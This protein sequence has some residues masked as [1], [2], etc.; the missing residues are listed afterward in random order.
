MWIPI[1][2]TTKNTYCPLLTLTSAGRGPQ[3]SCHCSP[4][5]QSHVLP[6]SWSQQPSSWSWKQHAHGSTLGST[7][8]CMEVPCTWLHST[9][10][11]SQS[12][13]AC[14]VESSTTTAPT[15]KPASW[16]PVP[17]GILQ[18]MTFT[19]GGKE[20][21]KHQNSLCH[22]ATVAFTTTMDT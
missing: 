18:A 16:T 20:K 12:T 14:T 5:E 19:H 7:A 13:S 21:R 1:A 11:H 2:F 3:S 15:Y 9:W 8:K 6:S 4:M 17:R 10:L 22:K